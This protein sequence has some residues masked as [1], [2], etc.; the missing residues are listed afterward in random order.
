MGKVIII[1]DYPIKFNYSCHNISC[2]TFKYLFYI[3]DMI[4][5]FFRRDKLFYN[6]IAID[7]FPEKRRKNLRLGV[8]NNYMKTQKYVVLNHETKQK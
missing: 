1:G 2:K 5:I 7:Y 8:I 6:R 3:Q 4:N